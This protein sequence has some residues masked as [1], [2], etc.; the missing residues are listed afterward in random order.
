MKA[1][2]QL[3]RYDT[4]DAEKIFE[5]KDLSDSIFWFQLGG[6]LRIDSEKPEAF[7]L[8]KTK[9]GNFFEHVVFWSHGVEKSYKREE[10]F[11][12]DK[13]WLVRWLETGKRVDLLEKLFGDEIEDA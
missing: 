7:I 12:V 3:R 11:P 6:I 1:I 10:I 5:S 13:D 8:Y 2:H 9:K 4:S